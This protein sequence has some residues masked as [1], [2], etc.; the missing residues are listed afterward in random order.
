MHKIF[1][2]HSEARN[3]TQECKLVA[4]SSSKSQ[5]AEEKVFV[6]QNTYISGD[7]N[8]IGR[9]EKLLNFNAVFLIVLLFL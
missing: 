6:Y 4:L 7:I 9:R 3:N 2:C 5:P 8:S 1:I